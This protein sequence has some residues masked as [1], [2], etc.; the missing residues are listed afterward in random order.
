MNQ[1]E[2]VKN[3]KV[4]QM[5]PEHFAR[6]TLNEYR[7]KIA[8]VNPAQETE[9]VSPVSLDEYEV[10]YET[11]ATGQVLENLNKIYRLLNEDDRPTGQISHSLSVGDLIQADETFYRVALMGFEE[12]VVA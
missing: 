11:Q 2:V 6:L 7:I 1:V 3:Y 9:V 5:K 8:G 10:T 12:V 4:W